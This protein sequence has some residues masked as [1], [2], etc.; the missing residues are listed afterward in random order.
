MEGGLG[1]GVANENVARVKT[2]RSV[3]G[4]CKV[5]YSGHKLEKDYKGEFTPLIWPSLDGRR[6]QLKSPRLP[7]QGISP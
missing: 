3:G 5:L 2:A 7:G 1:A 4:P 6:I